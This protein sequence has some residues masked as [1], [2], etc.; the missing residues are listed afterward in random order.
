[1]LEP[2]Q[3]FPASCGTAL[4]QGFPRAVGHGA[5]SPCCSDSR[6]LNTEA[7]PS[8]APATSVPVRTAPLLGAG[9]GCVD[10]SSYG[11][12]WQVVGLRC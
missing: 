3:K 6:R 5:S 8:L 10:L 1:M 7:N 2:P 11:S 9:D 12:N 4:G